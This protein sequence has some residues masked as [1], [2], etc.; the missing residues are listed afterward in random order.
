MFFFLFGG[1]FLVLWVVFFGYR[2]QYLYFFVL[3][4]VI[5]ILPFVGFVVFFFFFLLFVFL[6]VYLSM[7]NLFWAICWFFSFFHRIMYAPGVS[8]L[9]LIWFSSVSCVCVIIFCPFRL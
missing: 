4:L 5:Q 3:V 7:K 1:V 8:V 9:V 2:R 6:C